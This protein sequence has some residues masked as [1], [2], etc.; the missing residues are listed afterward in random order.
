MNLLWGAANEPPIH[1]SQGSHRYDALTTPRALPLFTD[2]SAFVTLCDA[3]SGAPDPNGLGYSGYGFTGTLLGHLD[4]IALH[5]AVPGDFIV[6]GPGWGDHVVGIVSDV[7]SG[8]PLCVSHGQEAG[9]I[10]VRHSVEVRAHRAPWRVL[11][12]VPV[13]HTPQPPPTTP[14]LPVTARDDMVR[15]LKGDVD[16]PDKRPDGKPVVEAA[17][18]YI[19]DA[20]LQTVQQVPNPAWL[21]DAAWVLN[22]DGRVLTPGPGT[23]V[24]EIAGAQGVQ[25]QVVSSEF[26]RPL[27]TANG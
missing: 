20:D 2:C 7:A 9:P 3:W 27:V 17:T 1:Y 4:E 10:K 11:R 24:V 15:I 26:L 6:Y 21:R 23:T 12:N 14:P 13:G 25:V 16:T 19:V 22:L 5:D 18:V 8:D